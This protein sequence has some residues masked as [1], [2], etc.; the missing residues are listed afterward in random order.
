MFETGSSRDRFPE[1]PTP[2]VKRRVAE[3]LARLHGLV[4]PQE[5][6]TLELPVLPKLPKLSP[7]N[8]SKTLSV[9]TSKALPTDHQKLEVIGDAGL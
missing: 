1:V 7:T 6:E 5:S 2:V 3:G 8:S 9:S 4:N